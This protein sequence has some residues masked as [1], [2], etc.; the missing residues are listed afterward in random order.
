MSL[1]QDSAEMLVW[2]IIKRVNANVKSKDGFV[3]LV[4]NLDKNHC[5]IDL[6]PQI[7]ELNNARVNFKHYGNIPSSIDVPKFIN[8]CREFLSLNARKIDVDLET[9][10]S[11]DR[12]PFPKIR[13]RLKKSEHY[14]KSENVRDALI[15]SSIAFSEL[16]KIAY[17]K[18]NVD[19]YAI[20]RMRESHDIWPEE[21]QDSAREFTHSL[22]A[23]LENTLNYISLGQFGY[24]PE[25]VLSVKSMCY[26]VNLSGTEKILGVTS[27]G[28]VREKVESVTFINNLIVE[29][30]RK[31]GF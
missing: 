20:D 26:S 18:I 8:N 2:E 22:T 17:S 31:L 30:S 15:E 29:A 12:V 10:S 24:S 4:E 14:I 21:N 23:T 6:K 3:T 25:Y 9:V 5:G 16:E 7:F 1:L 28:R 13:E 11:F 19:D 27:N